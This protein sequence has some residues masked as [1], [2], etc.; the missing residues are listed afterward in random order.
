MLNY[1]TF[2]KFSKL[3]CTSFSCWAKFCKLHPKFNVSAINFSIFFSNFYRSWRDYRIRGDFPTE[4]PSRLLFLNFNL[5]DCAFCIKCKCIKI[6]SGCSAIFIT[7][8]FKLFRPLQIGNPK[9]LEVREYLLDKVYYVSC[10]R[11]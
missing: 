8:I 1:F 3:K 4:F 10:F 7:I 5:F 2:C 6:I 9:A 11:S